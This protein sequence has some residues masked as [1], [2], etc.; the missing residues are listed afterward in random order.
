MG[1]G[2]LG[3]V[4][5]L[6]RD[7]KDGPFAGLSYPEGV[8]RFVPSNLRRFGEAYVSALPR[9]DAHRVT[10]KSM[11][12]FFYAGLIALALPKARMVNCVR[13]PI[14]TCLS[15]YTHQL[16]HQLFNYDLT[17]IGRFYR[18]YARL[19]E[20]WHDVL[21]GRILDVRY[22]DFVSNQ[23]TETARL[24]EFCGLEW[25]DACLSF[26]ETRRPVHTASASQVRQPIYTSSVRRWTHYQRHLQ[27]L[28]DALGSYAD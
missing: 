8:A 2:E 9:R 24:L 1:G 27:P 15:C 13:D 18:L 16:A 19:M 12:S 23:E 14:D 4:G 28:L 26:Y 21:P 10:D 11:D 20:H 3:A 7:S 25:E 17:E 5:P 22:E 6:A